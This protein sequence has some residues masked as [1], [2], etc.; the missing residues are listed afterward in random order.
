MNE[1]PFKFKDAQTFFWAKRTMHQTFK[2]SLTNGAGRSFGEQIVVV[3]VVQWCDPSL[4]F[5]PPSFLGLEW[6]AMCRIDPFV[7]IAF[8]VFNACTSM[9]LQHFSVN[10]CGINLLQKLLKVSCWWKNTTAA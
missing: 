2:R 4:D 7:V 1:T 5:C 9:G 3:V 8:R 6:P 10:I